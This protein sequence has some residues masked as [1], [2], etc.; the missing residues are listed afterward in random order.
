MAKTLQFRRDNTTNLSSETG[1]IAEIFM[2]TEKNTLVVMD[3]TT[4]GGHPLVSEAGGN[5]G[6]VTITDTRNNMFSSNSALYVTGGV[7]IGQDMAVSGR[8][9]A[10]SFA[11]STN[12]NSGA[13]QT[14]GGIGAWGN[15]NLG[16]NADIAGVL[17]VT[18]N[19][20]VGGIKTNNYFY[21]NGTPVSFGGGSTYGNTQVATYLPTHS[22]VVGASTVNTTNL[23]V[24]G[25]TVD[26]NSS[27]TNFNLGV[28][29]GRYITGQS[30]SKLNITNQSNGLYLE[31][32]SNAVLDMAG[33]TVNLG[34]STGTGT[35]T[36]QMSVTDIQG[37]QESTSTSTGALRVT[38]GVGIGGNVTAG[39][40]LRA[41]S[42][43]IGTA[44]SGTTGE[45]RAT[46]NVTAYY[47]SDRNLKENIEDIPN[48]L[49][50]VNHIGGKLFDWSDN[51]I[52]AHGGADG[53]FVTKQ[54][55]GVIAQDVQE[56]FPRAVK[57]REDG[58]L[59]VDYE[60]LCA[61]AFAAIKEL[62]D[63]F[64]NLGK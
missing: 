41:T 28:K 4:A 11:T 52:Q 25:G 7:T 60:K 1:S 23:T 37:V 36:V 48:A 31:A 40:N 5:I 44:A 64:N 9:V 6:R 27:S 57:T 62:T 34:Q 29:V 59:A 32:G 22:G 58:T 18:G 17:T 56:V 47:S 3:G 12:I 42:L 2:D 35:F 21:A 43:G 33:T 13:I 49:A 24:T 16:E 20:N 15:L 10:C 55:F 45:I 26:L 19:A 51:Y 46:N 14:N 53:Y 50:V 54:D 38:G 8:I 30:G 63:K 61:L 39:G